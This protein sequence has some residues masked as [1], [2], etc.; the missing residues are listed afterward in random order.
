MDIFA[1]GLWAGA[2]FKAI[3]RKI[4]PTRIKVRLAVFWGVFPDLFAFTPGFLWLL[5]NVLSGNLSLSGL[6][7]PSGVE[8]APQDGHPMVHLTSTL[9]SISHS[10][11][12]FILIFG[13]VFLIFRRPV[14]ELSG[15][16]LHI[17]MDIPS[18]SYRFYPTPFLW[19]VSGWKFNGY[20]WG[21]P[22]FMVLNYSAIIIA[23]LLL[24][25][26]KKPNIS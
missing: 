11:I 20:S 14:W 9:Y 18:H 2:A 4:H 17:L 22:W 3:N 12:V 10:V 24:R 19:P 15:W 16:L 23:Y 8:P 13:L 1:H 25:K 6:H 21:Q 5:W 26:N 7:R